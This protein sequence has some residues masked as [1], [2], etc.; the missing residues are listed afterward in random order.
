[1]LQQPGYI[2]PTSALPLFT[3]L[4]IFLLAGTWVESGT[5]KLVMAEATHTEGHNGSSETYE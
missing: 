4:L 2:H 3:S 5:A 1:M